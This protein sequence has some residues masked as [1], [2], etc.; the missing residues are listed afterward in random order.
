MEKAIARFVGL[1]CINRKGRR[2][3]MYNI[4]VTGGAGFVGLHLVRE[5]HTLGYNVTVVDSLE[6]QVHHGKVPVFPEG[7]KFVQGDIGD[8]KV[9]D[10]VV[11]GTNIIFH[12]AALVGQGQGQYEIARY[13]E[14]GVQATANML[15][16]LQNNPNQVIKII[17][18]GSIAAYG[19]GAYRV[20]PTEGEPYNLYPDSRTT[21]VNGFD[22]A[23]DEEAMVI[24]LPLSEDMPMRPGSIYGLTKKVQ[25]D[26][27]LIYGKMK[28]IPCVSLRYFNIVGE[29]QSLQNAYTGIMAILY[30]QL[31]E[32]KRP[33]IFEDGN[34]IRD[35][36]SVHDI[37]QANIKALHVFNASGA[38]NIGTG[39]G[40]PL[41]RLL[42][43]MQQKMK[44]EHVEPIIS[45]KF[46]KGDTRH[47]IA[48]ITKARSVLGY[49]PSF[50]L[51]QIVDDFIAWADHE[52]PK[53]VVEEA[54]KELEARGLIE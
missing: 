1:K 35:F 44:K 48:D 24:P 40:T 13:F 36:V 22:Y 39:K 54:N 33:L 43:V 7:V 47:L 11:P 51:D 16:Y 53:V 49:Q 38:F 10:Q 18:A 5:L 19:E 12:E 3:K 31:R 14:K 2:R 15:D 26:M 8:K 52:T 25:E 28:G 21:C 9:L 41:L 17:L 45:G 4:L 23:V 30:A 20:I 42:Q 29:G 27:V 6:E 37:V 32:E 46:R 34:Q 50:E